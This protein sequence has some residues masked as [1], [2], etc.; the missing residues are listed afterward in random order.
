MYTTSR[1]GP[2]INRISDYGGA[3]RHGRACALFRAQGVS[4]KSRSPAL[5]RLA[6]RR[7]RLPPQLLAGGLFTRCRGDALDYL[8]DA[9][10]QAGG[11]RRYGGKCLEHP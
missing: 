11:S 10:A 2:D 6:P 7:D 4:H 3:R 8:D 1:F 5:G 9:L